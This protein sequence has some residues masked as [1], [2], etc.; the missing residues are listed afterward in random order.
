MAARNEAWTRVVGGTRL[1]M[2]RLCDAGRAP[3]EARPIRRDGMIEPTPMDDISTIVI[4]GAG[5]AGAK[6]AEALRKEGFEGGIHLFGAEA[7]RPYI[8][9][10]LSKQY[11]RGE[12][13]IDGAWVHPEGWYAEQ[14]VDLET[15]AE[16]TS[17]DPSGRA[18]ALA[19]GRR[20]AFDRL[21]LATGSAPRRP[22]IPGAELEGV[23]LLRTIED[24][25]ALRTAAGTGRGETV[26]IGGGWIG[27]EVAASLR[28]LGHEVTLVVPAARRSSGC[29][30]PR[31]AACTPTSTRRTASACVPN[32]RVVAIHGRAG[33]RPRRSSSPTGRAS[34]PT[35]SSPVSGPPRGRASP[36]RRGCGSKTGILTDERLETSVPGI[37][38]A[39]DV[40]S[41]VHPLFGGRVRSGHWDNARRQGRVAALNMLGRGEAYARVPYFYS[42]QFD[43]GMEY[44]GYAPA[45][46]RVVVRGDLASREFVAFW[47]RDGRVAAG[48]NAN[49]WKVNGA[50]SELVASGRRVDPERLAD[51]DVPIPELAAA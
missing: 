43:L 44:A 23:R 24:S 15:S 4:A 11:L 27:A 40:A 37:F 28:Q 22:D 34:T 10:P 5:L 1:G 17:I 16:V 20:V 7:H 25:D 35:S 19:D 8:R 26:V 6:A 9:P 51:P 30:V 48:M 21:L 14:R 38:A 29:S 39:G 41:A 42:D 18:V 36:R 13:A 45:W 31:S 3:R 50:I 46:D 33:K 47:L 2:R 12:E 49:V 32:Q